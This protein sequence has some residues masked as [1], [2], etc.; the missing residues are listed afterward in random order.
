MDRQVLEGGITEAKVSTPTK[1][2]NSLHAGG[3]RRNPRRVE[4]RHDQLKEL[5]KSGRIDA[6]EVIGREV[7]LTGAHQTQRRS[8]FR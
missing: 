8:N 7:V 2:I 5:V 3:H 6:Y 4:V 1:A